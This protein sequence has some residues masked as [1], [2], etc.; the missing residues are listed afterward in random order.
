MSISDMAIFRQ[1]PAQAYN[2]RPTLFCPT[3][4]LTS[5][6][7]ARIVLRYVATHSP[8]SFTESRFCLSRP[9]PFF[10]AVHDP[11]LPNH[12]GRRRRSPCRLS[13]K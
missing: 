3:L 5:P 12:R 8:E 10:G 13:H 1:L 7:G 6:P 9:F 2:F 4:F 11:I